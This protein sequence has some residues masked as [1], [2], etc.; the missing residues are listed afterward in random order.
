MFLFS[1]SYTNPSSV[2]ESSSLE[3]NANASSVLAGLNDVGA[4]LEVRVGYLGMCISSKTGWIC[5]RGSEKLAGIVQ[6]AKAGELSDPLNLIY[7]A[8][9]FKR[10]MAFVGLLYVPHT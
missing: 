9:T 3:V 10:E 6:Q 1:L 8:D 7:V 2:H 5:S 4:T